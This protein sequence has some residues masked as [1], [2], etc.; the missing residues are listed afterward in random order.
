[1]CQEAE[2]LAADPKPLIE[3]CRDA[4]IPDASQNKP[5]SFGKFSVF[6][7]SRWL[8]VPF[9]AALVGQYFDDRYIWNN[10][11]CLDVAKRNR[12]REG[13][14]IHWPRMMDYQA[15]REHNQRKLKTLFGLTGMHLQIEDQAAPCCYVFR[16]EEPYSVQSIHER[17]AKFGVTTELDVNEKLIA[18]PCHPKLGDGQLEY[19]FAAVRGMINPCHTYVR[20][21]PETAK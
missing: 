2:E 3:D 11:H 4:L 21:N 14:Q 5:G 13:L 12:T 20:Q 10:F 17:L 8:P 16:S 19:V 6:D 1:L 15:R 18:I 7:F 9:G